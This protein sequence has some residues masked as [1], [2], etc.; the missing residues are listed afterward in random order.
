MERALAVRQLLQ[1]VSAAP[2]AQRL[3]LT[4][5]GA[6]S[7]GGLPLLEAYSTIVGMLIDRLVRT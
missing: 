5:L 2:V 3:Q 1:F 6:R 4:H 7:S